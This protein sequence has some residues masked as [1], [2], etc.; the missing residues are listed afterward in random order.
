V[1]DIEH[2]IFRMTPKEDAIAMF[3]KDLAEYYQLSPDNPMV[4]LPF[5]KR[6]TVHQIFMDQAAADA[7]CHKQYFMQVWRKNPLCSHIKLR[8]H[9]RFALCDTCVDFRDLQMKQQ[10]SLQRLILKKAQLEHHAFVKKERQL[11][12]WRRERGRDPNQDVVSMIVDAAD[13]AK[14]A[15]PYHH[16]A[17]HESSKALRVPVHLMGVLVHGDYVHAYTYYENFKQGNNVTIEA[18]H[19]ALCAKMARDGRLPSTFFLQLDNTTKQCKS[20]YMIG[21]LGYLVFRGVFNHIVVSFLPV[22]HTH[23]DIDQVFSR[24]SVYLACHDALNMAQLHAAIRQSYQTREGLRADCGF[25]D[26]CANFSHW[27]KP[28]LTSYEGITRYRQFRFYKTDGDVRV[29][30][31]QHTSEGEEWAGIRGQDAFTDVFR[32]DPPEMM[33]NVPDTQRR[34]IISE[35]LIDAQRASITRLASRRHI[36][37]E[38]IADVIE[39]M[40]SV[41]DDAALPFNWNLKQL[42][43]YEAPEN[44]EMKESDDEEIDHIPHAYEYEVE[45]VVLLKPPEDAD[46]TF[47]LAKVVALGEDNNEGEYQVYWMHTNKDYGLYTYE[48]DAQGRPSMDWVWEQ[49]VQDK[50]V[51]CRKGRKLTARSKNLVRNWVERWTQ[52]RNIAQDDFDIEPGEPLEVEIDQDVD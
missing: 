37:M 31:R 51:M 44:E 33:E 12:I 23:E 5:P 6:S 34:E 3:L 22:G 36:P 46:R 28:Y 14:Y 11:Y 50:V 7:R 29:Q 49:S 48:K 8:K 9:L 1:V 25:W 52:E 38:L 40:E 4:F 18:I 26:R 35:K 47:W 27:I 10:T 20:R 43:N 13:Q 19:S 32:E 24:L 17:T 42:L 39:G 45:T 15:L 21:W 41:G 30:A 2:H 16:I